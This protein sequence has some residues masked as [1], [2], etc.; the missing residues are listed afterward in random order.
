MS[1][2]N[3][4]KTMSKAPLYNPANPAKQRKPKI[5]HPWKRYNPGFI[6]SDK[7]D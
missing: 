1:R 4:H 3:P 5:G 6:G 2:E 7:R